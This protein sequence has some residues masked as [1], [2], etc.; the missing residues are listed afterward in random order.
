LLTQ[1]QGGRHAPEE[2]RD[3][4][5]VWLRL[6]EECG[7]VGGLLYWVRDALRESCLPSG[8]EESV[9]PRWEAMAEALDERLA[10]ATEASGP[11]VAAMLR[12]H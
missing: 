12:R 3:A 8:M 10:S 7:H 4:L 9:V 2:I 11:V 5:R 6:R 1:F